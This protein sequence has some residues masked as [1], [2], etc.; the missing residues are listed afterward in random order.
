MDDKDENMNYPLAQ[1]ES[2]KSVIIELFRVL[3]I[4]MKGFKYQITMKIYLS[5][6][7][8]NEKK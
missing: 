4:K 8:Q 1:L 2:S 3:L 5:K 6:Q 7:K